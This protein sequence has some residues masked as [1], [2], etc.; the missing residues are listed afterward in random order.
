MATMLLSLRFPFVAA[1]AG[2]LVLG[3][4][5]C[6]LLALLFSLLLLAAWAAL[7][8]SLRSPGGRRREVR[9]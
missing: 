4:R 9:T 6:A 5:L 3:P 7:R 2:L 8:W 1:I